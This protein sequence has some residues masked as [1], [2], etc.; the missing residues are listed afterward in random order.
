MS[1]HNQSASGL[2]EARLSSLSR[3]KYARP[4]SENSEFFPDAKPLI[5]GTSPE[6]AVVPVHKLWT[7]LKA[8]KLRTTRIC[9]SS[10]LISKPVRERVEISAK[11]M[12][13]AHFNRWTKSV[14]L[15]DFENKAVL[16]HGHTHLLTYR[17]WLPH[18]VQ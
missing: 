6:Q 11:Y 1:R 5:R 4:T 17:P 9:L 8:W 7:P 2:P 12:G 14:P 3:A 15:S 18:T 16:E 13:P 10:F